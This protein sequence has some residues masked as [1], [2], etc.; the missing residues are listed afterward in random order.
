MIKPSQIV[1]QIDGRL[2]I[3]GELTIE[4][5]VNLVL[6]M[7]GLSYDDLPDTFFVLEAGSISGQFFNFPSSISHHMINV[8]TPV[9]DGFTMSID[10]T[11]KNSKFRKELST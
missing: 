1:L 6:D 2:R 8:P 9:P 5:G 11:Q 4:E 3:A 7:E 10:T